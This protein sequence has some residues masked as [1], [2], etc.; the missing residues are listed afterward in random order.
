MGRGTWGTGWLSSTVLPR[1]LPVRQ[2]SP[3]RTKH[4]TMR[5]AVAEPPP[6]G[7]QRRDSNTSA[8]GGRRTSGQLLAK[9]R[10]PLCEMNYKKTKSV[11]LCL[12]ILSTS[13]FCLTRNLLENTPRKIFP[14]RPRVHWLA[15]LHL[16]PRPTRQP[17]SQTILYTLNN[18]KHFIRY[19]RHIRSVGKQYT[20]TSLVRA[21]V[22]ARRGPPSLRRAA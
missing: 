20:T 6:K 15:A 18:L 14:S 5:L 9:T 11:T 16:T 4:A 8:T 19:D 10:Q 22:G 21:R 1:R 7:T 2:A 3:Q 17:P 13:G 12:L